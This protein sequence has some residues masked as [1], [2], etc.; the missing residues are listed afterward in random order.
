[1]STYYIVFTQYHTLLLTWIEIKCISNDLL[2][3]FLFFRKYA[4]ADYLSFPLVSFV[5]RKLRW[6]NYILSAF[7]PKCTT[8]LSANISTSSQIADRF[9]LD[10]VAHTLVVGDDSWWDDA[11]T[12]KRYEYDAD[13]CEWDTAHSGY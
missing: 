1:M 6:R 13:G 11:L 8:D 2:S 4:C 5:T 12:W 10:I 7:V 9:S 3:L